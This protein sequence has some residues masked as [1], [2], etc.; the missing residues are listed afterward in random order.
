MTQPALRRH[1]RNDH[2]GSLTNPSRSQITVTESLAGEN[3]LKN[4]VLSGGLRT[5]Q[6]VREPGRGPDGGLM[7]KYADE[8][9]AI[10][11][12]D[13]DFAQ[14]FGTRFHR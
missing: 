11:A 6:Y 1:I 7:A 8:C 12:A 13:P 10:A 9:E 5:A 4:W 14:R 2:P 3:A